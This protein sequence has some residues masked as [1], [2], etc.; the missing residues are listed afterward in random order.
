MYSARYS[1]QVELLREGAA[2]SVLREGL[3]TAKRQAR[4]QM[5]LDWE[6][7]LGEPHAAAQEVVLVVRPH[8]KVWLE[9][10]V[11]HL[12]YRVTQ[13]LTGHG[14]FGEYL[15]RIG[16][17]PT[18]QCHQCGAASDSVEHTVEECP[19]WAS[20]RRALADAIGPDLSLE[21]LMR[22]LAS[23]DKDRQ[24]A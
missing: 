18:T 4:R 10:G 7:H 5:L 6:Q 17:E 21:S 16:K 8:L 11:G 3:A 2:E 22:A 1:C 23:G 9:N 12:T 20:D 14:C 24:Q 19:R 15:S 13:V